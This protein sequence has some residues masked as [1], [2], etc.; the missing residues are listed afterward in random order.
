MEYNWVENIKRTV[1]QFDY[2]N[3]WGFRYGWLDTKCLDYLAYVTFLLPIQQGT[4]FYN[5]LQSVMYDD[6]ELK[7][8]D[9]DM[10]IE[11]T[12]FFT[13]KPV[14]SIVVE[15]QKS[16]VHCSLFCDVLSLSCFLKNY[17]SEG[18]RTKRRVPTHTLYIWTFC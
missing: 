6:P 14:K 15:L 2:C 9:F 4:L 13:T 12:N 16:K 11:N 18:W 3:R 8:E 7:I 5:F 10:L 17:I 1:L